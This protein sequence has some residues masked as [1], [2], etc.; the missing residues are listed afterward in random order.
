MYVN[1]GTNSKVFNG[2][3]YLYAFIEFIENGQLS[4]WQSGRDF[5]LSLSLWFLC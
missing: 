2:I 3:K 4:D 5:Q 1:I